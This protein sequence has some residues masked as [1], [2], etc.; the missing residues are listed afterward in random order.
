MVLLNAVGFGRQIHATSPADGGR[1]YVD[2]YLLVAA[3]GGWA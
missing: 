1:A 2:R 3:G